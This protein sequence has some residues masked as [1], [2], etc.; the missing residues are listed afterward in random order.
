ML[1]NIPFSSRLKNCCLNSLAQHAIHSLFT[2]LPFFVPFFVSS[3]LKQLST[4]STTV[5]SLVQKHTHFLTQSTREHLWAVVQFATAN[6]PSPDCPLLRSFFFLSLLCPYS[7][8]RTLLPLTTLTTI[9]DTFSFSLTSSF[10]NPVTCPESVSLKCV[11]AAT[12]GRHCVTGHCCALWPPNHHHYYHH[13]TWQ[14]LLPLTTT[15]V[16]FDSLF[17]SLSLSLSLYFIHS[18]FS[19]FPFFLLDVLPTFVITTLTL[20]PLLLPVGQT[21]PIHTSTLLVVTN[22]YRIHTQASTSVNTNTHIQPHT[23][24]HSH[25]RKCCAVDQCRCLSHS[26][27]VYFSPVHVCDQTASSSDYA[28]NLLNCTFIKSLLQ[29]VSPN[30]RPTVTLAH[31]VRRNVF[32]SFQ[33]HITTP[34]SIYLFKNY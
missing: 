5:K 22:T 3:S 1:H 11:G 15:T 10:D 2:L 13:L 25:A 29:A 6:W 21:K 24:S 33:H 9:C 14:R 32:H 18:P 8:C 16:H 23:H 26:A 4:L 31:A 7:R 27:I 28:V 34:I 17:F 30:I 12:F 20:T 19:L